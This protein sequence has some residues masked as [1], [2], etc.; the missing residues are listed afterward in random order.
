MKT[1]FWDLDD[2][3]ADFNGYVNK[4][5]NTNYKVGEQ[6]LY[7]EWEELRTNHQRLFRELK[8]K[9]D[10]IDIAYSLIKSGNIHV[11]ILT[12]LP[13]D[14]H[15]VWQYAATDKIRWCDEFLLGIPVFF[16]IYAHDKHRH[17]KPGDLLID[18]KRS[19]CEEWN[20]AGGKAFM[21]A[22]DIEALK[23][24]LN[25]NGVLND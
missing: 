25:E 17:C 4:T 10:V 18:D 20:A 2:V 23:I 11:R 3:L 8:P 9:R 13:L 22:G 7:S 24:F 14:E 1:I 5:L 12:A 15:S 16:G 21:F 6:M 19:N